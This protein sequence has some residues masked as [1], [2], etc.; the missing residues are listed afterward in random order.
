[1]RRLTTIH[2]STVISAT[3]AG[4]RVLVSLLVAVSFAALVLC[5]PYARKGAKLT[6]EARGSTIAANAPD[7]GWGNRP[8]AM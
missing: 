8:I 4:M 2:E 1:M 3:V 7:A 6:H 5:S